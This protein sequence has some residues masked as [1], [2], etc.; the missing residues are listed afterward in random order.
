LKLLDKGV[1][2]SLI[3][4]YLVSN[5]FPGGRATFISNSD[6]LMNSLVNLLPVDEDSVLG[7]LLKQFG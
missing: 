7:F 1:T 5:F 3:A 2:L 4:F 6:S